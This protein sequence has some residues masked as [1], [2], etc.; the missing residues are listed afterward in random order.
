[1][2]FEFGVYYAGGTMIISKHSISVIILTFNSD[3]N[4]LK[5]TI[6]SVILQKE[7]DI[8]I[9]ISDDGSE[10]NH[11]FKLKKLFS[12]M[13]FDS[14]IFVQSDYNSGIVKNLQRAIRK[15][16][17]EY[18]K[19]ISP[20]DLLYSSYTLKEW[21]SFVLNHKIKISFG[22]PIYYNNDN[23]FRII[24]HRSVPKYIYAY[25]NPNCNNIRK[26]YLL[27]DDMALGAAFLI[28]KTVLNE[29]L[30]KIVDKVILGEDFS[31]SLMVFDGIELKLFDKNVIWYEY[32]H[33]I[34]TSGNEKFSKIML[35]DWENMHTE[36]R[37]IFKDDLF[38]R[39]F[40]LYIMLYN[41]FSNSHIKRMIKYFVLPEIIWWRIKI[42]LHKEYT[43]SICDFR[44]L[45][46]IIEKSD[47]I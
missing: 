34:S 29:Y 20:G 8:E 36:M 39:R 38:S 15:S 44:F 28:K 12:T 32:G 7:I 10:N 41:F 17:S 26:E 13:N 30:E 2:T 21:Y 37:K 16:N 27:L 43:D 35:Q 9:I 23:G 24:K 6:I 33:G 11:F 18:I 19:P 1:M 3:W 45:N 5:Q 40:S 25:R 31:Y 22:K 14:Y 4:K 46:S 42:T 47:M